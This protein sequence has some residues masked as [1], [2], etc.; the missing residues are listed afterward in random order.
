MTHAFKRYMDKLVKL[1]KGKPSINKSLTAA[2]KL[3]ESLNIGRGKEKT[4]DRGAR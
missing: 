2:K 3:A 4:K 1:D